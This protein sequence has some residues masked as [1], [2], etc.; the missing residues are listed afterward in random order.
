[1]RKKYDS[2]YAVTDEKFKK[3]EFKK[4]KKENQ[5]LQKV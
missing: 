2:F 4:V 3:E 5:L 1:M